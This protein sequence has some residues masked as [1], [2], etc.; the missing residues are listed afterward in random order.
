MSEGAIAGQ[1]MVG[2]AIVLLVGLPA[3][4]GITGGTAA[5]QGIPGGGAAD[6]WTAVGQRTRS[7]R[8]HKR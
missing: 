7:V 3:G 6:Q 4:H 8:D 5:V 2:G 1:G